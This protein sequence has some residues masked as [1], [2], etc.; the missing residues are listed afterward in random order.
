MYC[1]RRTSKKAR[2]SRFFNCTD[3]LLLLVILTTLS[4]RSGNAQTAYQEPPATKAV[5]V[6]DVLAHPLE[7]DGRIITLRD[8]VASSD[9]G[10]WLYSDKCPGIFVTYAHV[11][12]SA[13]SLQLPTIPPEMRLHSPKFNYDWQSSK[14][15]AAKRTR[16]LKTGPSQCLV[17]TYTGLFETRRDWSAAKKVYPNGTSTMIG[18]GHLNGSPG[19]LLMKSDDDVSLD[20]DCAR[21]AEHKDH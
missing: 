20:A 5:S 7:F 14:T 10:S 16:L 15:A 12:P 3:R 6:C 9:E 13:I 18:F 21:K 17:F 8:K 1:K 19:Q 11:W 2:S 4:F